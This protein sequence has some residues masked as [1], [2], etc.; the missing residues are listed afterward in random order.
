MGKDHAVVLDL[1]AGIN[2]QKIAVG[3]QPIVPRV[4]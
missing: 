3:Q 4:M 2:D 1:R